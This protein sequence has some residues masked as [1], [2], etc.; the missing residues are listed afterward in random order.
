MKQELYYRLLEI[1]D[2]IEN[3]YDATLISKK[4]LEIKLNFPFISDDFLNGIFQLMAMD[5]GEEFIIPKDN[6]LKLINQL[7]KECKTFYQPKR[8]NYV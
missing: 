6:S 4:A 7:I 8:I 3:D 1:K 2:L 5:M